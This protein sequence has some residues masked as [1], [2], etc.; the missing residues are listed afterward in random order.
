[1]NIHFTDKE[2]F[3]KLKS[4]TLAKVVVGSHMYGTQNIFGDN[5]SDIDYLHIYATSNN[6]LN[7]VFN[8]HH[9]LQYKEDGIDYNFV[10]LHTFIKNILNG[11]STINFEVVQSDELIGTDLEWLRMFKDDFITYTMIKSYNGF[12]KRDLKHFHKAKTEYDR[13]KRFGHIIRG[14]LYSRDMLY[15]QWDFKV[16]NDELKEIL[17]DLTIDNTL[18]ETYTNLTNNIRTELN[19]RLENKTLGYAQHFHP[20]KG[21]ILNEY[22]QEFCK[23]DIFIAKQFDLDITMYITS[24]ENW[25]TY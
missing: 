16:V 21:V 5:T 25:V 1:M 11:D 22:L 12:C 10:S 7:T 2:L 14:F 15:S 17:K 23:S 24:Y 19:K 8:T 3:E 4:A 6:E 20:V 18:I 9:Q 13:F